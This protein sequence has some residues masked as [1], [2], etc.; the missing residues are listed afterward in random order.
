[1]FAVFGTVSK[2]VESMR[3]RRTNCTPAFA[4]YAL[5]LIRNQQVAGSIPAG[6]SRKIQ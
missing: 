3:P 6:G 2:N 5:R 4:D 1:M